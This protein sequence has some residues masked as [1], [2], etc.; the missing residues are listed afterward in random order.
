[1][2]TDDPMIDD[3][4]DTIP[5]E[6]A[7]LLAALSQDAD[8]TFGVVDWGATTAKGR[9]RRHNE[10]AWGRRKNTWVCADGMGGREGGEFASAAAVAG[11]LDRVD[12]A[13]NSIDWHELFTDVNSEVMT[14][15]QDRGFANIGSTLVVARCRGALVTIA[16]VGDSRA[17]RFAIDEHDDADLR[18]VTED[19]NMQSELHAAGIN[20]RQY[21]R[22]GLS[23]SGLTS[24]IGL[25]RGRLRVDVVTIVVRRGDRLLLCSDGVHGQVDDARMRSCLRRTPC[26]AAADALTAA[27]DGRGGR[28][29]ATAVVLEFGRIEP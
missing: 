15:A 11:V 29:N 20:T 16:H 8:T 2:T 4:D 13:G 7:A 5:N 3:D 23:L 28:D 14:R 18:V 24:F 19:H 6:K 12:A 17:Y 10:D 21:R 26:Q 1:M 27:A 25:D 9:K 22:D